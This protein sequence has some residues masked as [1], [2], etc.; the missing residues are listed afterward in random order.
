MSDEKVMVNGNLTT[1]RIDSCKIVEVI[2]VQF[3]RGKGID[4]DVM[5]IVTQWRTKTG[6]LIHEWD[7]CEALK[8]K[9]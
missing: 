9:T 6:E 5:R 3:L 7:P 8:G 4:P 2:E 1:G